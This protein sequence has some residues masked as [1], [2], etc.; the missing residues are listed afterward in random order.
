MDRDMRNLMIASSSGNERDEF[1]EDS[2]ITRRLPPNTILQ[3]RKRQSQCRLLQMPAEI[4]TGIVDFLADN[5]PALA[6]LAIVNSDCCYLARSC[7]FAEIWF[8]YSS[9]AQQ[10]LAHLAKEA[11]HKTDV[12]TRTFA[13]SEQGLELTLHIAFKVHAW[14]RWLHVVL[15]LLESQASLFM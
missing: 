7:Q 10:L 3:G 12:M 13:T 11:P 4:L 5:K 2:R 1:G 9:H 15:E 8:D 6:A 14:K